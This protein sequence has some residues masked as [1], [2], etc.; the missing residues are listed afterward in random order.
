M[1]DVFLQSQFVCDYCHKISK[2]ETNFLKHRCKQMERMDMLRS[3]EGLLAKQSYDY[4]LKCQRRQSITDRV[5][6]STLNFT[7]F[8]KFANF[9][10]EVRMD[11]WKQYIKLMSNNKI[12]PKNWLH[13]NIVS[14]YINLTN[15][16]KYEDYIMGEFNQLI[17]NPRIIG[18]IKEF[19]PLE[20]LQS[21]LQNQIPVVLVLYSKTLRAH[22]NSLRS[23][24]MK[25]FDKYCEK[26]EIANIM[27]DEQLVS[28]IKTL[29][30]LMGF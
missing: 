2:G 22:F 1:S 29:V 6:I 11:D 21:V 15:N 10:F 24:E 28:K 3:K 5:F 16:S 20:L 18:Q 9:V 25:Q 4:W 17:D 12:S 19:T 14:Y 26:N 8:V 23:S 7:S 13:V 30:Q 27:K